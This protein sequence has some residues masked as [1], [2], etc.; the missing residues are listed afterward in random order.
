MVTLTE[1]PFF[2]DEIGFQH[3]LATLHSVRKYSQKLTN[4]KLK[5]TVLIAFETETNSASFLGT[6]VTLEWRVV[7]VTILYVVGA[8]NDVPTY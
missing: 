6:A 5:S 1:W 2:L 3:E 8:C 4:W 7:V